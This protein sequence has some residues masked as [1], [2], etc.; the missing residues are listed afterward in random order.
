MSRTP[1]LDKLKNPIVFCIGGIG[2]LLLVLSTVPKDIKTIDVI[3]WATNDATLKGVL[4]ELQSSNIKLFPFTIDK[5][6]VF[7]S[8]QTKELFDDIVQHPNFLTKGHVP[9]NLDYIGEWTNHAD[10]YLD[11]ILPQ[12]FN[13][14][15][16][17]T[18]ISLALYGSA[19]EQWKRR[20]ATKEE[21]CVI[22]RT[23]MKKSEEEYGADIMLLG[24][25]NDVY[26]FDYPMPCAIVATKA[27]FIEQCKIITESSHLYTVDTWYKTFASLFCPG[28]KVTI[29][30]SEYIVPLT[31][32]FASGIDPSD[33]IFLN[34]RWGFEFTTFKELS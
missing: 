15:G 1:F 22:G 33:N 29:I 19:T 28:T 32:V 5:T 30:R 17:R 27:P 12:E 10:K 14:H 6:I 8:W 3:C 4:K 7:Q 21:A 9:D 26:E 20:R 34:P 11:K 31:Q 24:G 13:D 16:E 18:K 25:E 23:M 2:D